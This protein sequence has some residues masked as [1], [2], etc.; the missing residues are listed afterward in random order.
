MAQEEEGSRGS[1]GAGGEGQGRAKVEVRWR[2][3]CWRKRVPVR[4]GM[5]GGGDVD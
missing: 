4:G 2:G 5:D 3:H 1:D